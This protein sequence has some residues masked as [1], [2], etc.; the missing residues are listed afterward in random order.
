MYGNLREVL[1][2]VTC[3]K[4]VEIYNYLPNS[5]SYHKHYMSPFQNENHYYELE[6]QFDKIISKVDG[7]VEQLA[8]SC[9]ESNSIMWSIVKMS[10]IVLMTST[11]VSYKHCFVLHCQSFFLFYLLCTFSA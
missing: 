1:N 3:D 7:K 4:G 5:R 8:F 2:L 6:V 9:C 11:I 10:S